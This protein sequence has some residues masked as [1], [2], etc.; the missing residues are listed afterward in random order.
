MV[1]QR[2]YQGGL[3]LQ[4]KEH[5]FRAGIILRNLSD[6]IRESITIDLIPYELNLERNTVGQSAEHSEKPEPEHLDN[7]NQGKA[8]VTRHMIDN[9][10]HGSD[11]DI[12]SGWEVIPH[13]DL[14]YLPTEG[15]ELALKNA[16][17]QEY[18]SFWEDDEFYTNYLAAPSYTNVLTPGMQKPWEEM[19]AQEFYESLGSKDDIFPPEPHPGSKVTE[20]GQEHTPR[21]EEEQEFDDQIR[22]KTMNEVSTRSHKQ[23]KQHELDQ[24]EYCNYQ[25]NLDGHKYSQ[26][27]DQNIKEK[28][29]P[30]SKTTTPTGHTL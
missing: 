8:S 17:G 5:L 11:N 30:I 20:W 6:L 25:K 18:D 19:S 15:D 16:S 1:T 24:W 12:E 4:V 3:K 10:T 23:P 13:L 26:E 21:P 28:L 29:N 9:C 14:K 7:S 2:I 22:Q 27:N